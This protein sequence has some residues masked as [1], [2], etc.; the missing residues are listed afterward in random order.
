[1]S[2]VY[3][4]KASEKNTPDR[5][6]ADAATLFR[7]FLDREKISLAEK[8]PLKVHFG[9]KGNE[10]FIPPSC[11]DGLIDVLRDRKIEA[12]YTETNALYR[13]QRQNRVNHEKL[14]CRTWI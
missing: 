9:E 10:T 3:F 8:L 11:F 7:L 5:I 4:M 2:K 13:G 14:A 12:C 1:M 6:S